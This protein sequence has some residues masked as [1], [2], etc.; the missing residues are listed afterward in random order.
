MTADYEA[1]EE[2]LEFLKD[3]TDITNVRNIMNTYLYVGE[4]DKLWAY[5]MDQPSKLKNQNVIYD[6]RFPEYDNEIAVS[7]KFARIRR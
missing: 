2:V 5:I 3:R 6:G 4:D 1:K 7:G